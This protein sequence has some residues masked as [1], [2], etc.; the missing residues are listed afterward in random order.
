MPSRP[1]TRRA[2]S[3]TPSSTTTLPTSTPRSWHGLHG[4]RGGLS[5]HAQRRGVFR[6]IVDLQAAIHCFIKDHNDAPKPFI[7]TKSA[8][9]ILERVARVNQTIESLH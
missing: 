7:W 1:K 2:G 4:I 3:S 9:G 8:D 5:L 6:S